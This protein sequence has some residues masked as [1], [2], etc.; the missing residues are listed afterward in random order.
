MTIYFDSR[1]EE[2]R[3][4]EE[5]IKARPEAV[6]EHVAAIEAIDAGIVWDVTLAAEMP[7][8]PDDLRLQVHDAV[9]KSTV[10]CQPVNS[11]NLPDYE[12]IEDRARAIHGMIW[13]L[14]TM[15][16]DLHTIFHDVASR[17]S[18]GFSDD[19]RAPLRTIYARGEEERKRLA[20]PNDVDL[21]EITVN[22]RKV[23]V[24]S[25][26]VSY[27]D[28]VE[29]VYGKREMAPVVSITY[30]RAEHGKEG[31]LSPGRSVRVKSGTIISAAITDNA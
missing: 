20:S 11:K 24:R 5:A 26:T 3:K 22:A 18:Q 29:W 8:F 16:W 25:T 30:C 23:S 21:I 6:N 31:I 28:V 2:L 12:S 4:V 27:N 9:L 19:P 17:K 1:H 13:D 7:G 15:I 10:A 14:H